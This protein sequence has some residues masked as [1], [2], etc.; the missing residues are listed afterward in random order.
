MDLTGCRTALEDQFFKT[1]NEE[2]VKRMKAAAKANATKEELKRLTGIENEHVLDAMVKLNVGPAATVV[3]SVLPMVEIAW[4][5]GAVDEKERKLI[6]EEAGRHGLKQDSEG[7]LVLAR[8]LDEKPDASWGPL[9]TSYVTEL[10]HALSAEDRAL[11]KS[12]VLGHAQRVASASGKVMGL[13]S[14]I[15]KAER[16]VLDRLATAFT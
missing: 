8:W 16:A 5:D 9:W 7:A 12:E 15:S 13:G 2:L 3:M 11:L 10:S 6:L 1:Q 4:A 14:G